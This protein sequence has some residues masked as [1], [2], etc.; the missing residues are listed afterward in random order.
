MSAGFPQGPAARPLFVPAARLGLEAEYP[1]TSCQI[2]PKIHQLVIAGWGGTRCWRSMKNLGFRRTLLCSSK[3]NTKV[4]F[5]SEVRLAEFTKSITSP[6]LLPPSCFLKQGVTGGG[7]NCQSYHQW[8][9]PALPGRKGGDRKKTTVEKQL[10]TVQ[11]KAASG[12]ARWCFT[13]TR[14]VWKYTLKWT[15]CWFY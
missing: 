14:I 2:A 11:E 1:I 4:L 5:C 12:G 8:N 10:D 6:T 9:F 7:A 3:D 15:C 13:S